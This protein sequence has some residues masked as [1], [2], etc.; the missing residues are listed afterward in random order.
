MSNEDNYSLGDL[1][2]VEESSFE[3][4]EEEEEEEG[5]EEEEEEEEEEA[6]E[7]SYSRDDNKTPDWP[8]SKD[9]KGGTQQEM[10][11][12]TDQ[13]C[14]DGGEE[15]GPSHVSDHDDCDEDYD[16]DGPGS[17]LL[18]IAGSREGRHSRATDG[19]DS[20]LNNIGEDED[21]EEEEEDSDEDYIELPAVTKIIQ[22]QYTP[23]P[24]PSPSPPPP[25]APSAKD[26]KRKKKKEELEQK[27]K[28]RARSNSLF[29]ILGRRQK[30]VDEAAEAKQET[31][32]EEE[33]EVTTWSIRP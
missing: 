16:E 26:E 29:K 17:L 11:D 19:D 22:P 5:D 15:A 12:E 27:M 25:P 2:S 4:E 9:C 30:L 7:I 28:P 10:G 20:S 24:P 18:A 6:E 14:S 23:S 32:A 21:E 31:L 1:G 13:P 33:D 3:E 8:P